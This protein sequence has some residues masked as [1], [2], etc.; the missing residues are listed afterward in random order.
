MEN[1]VWGVHTVLDITDCHADKIRSAEIITQWIK[2]LVDLIKMEPF[3][4]PTVVRFGKDDKFG[5]TAV[6]LIQTS[7]IIAHF[8]EDTNSVFIDVFSCKTYDPWKVRD[9]CQDVFGGVIKGFKILDR[10]N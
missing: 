5:F 2:D 1:N 4:E 8:S 10:K 9:F 3:G 6:Q 7:N